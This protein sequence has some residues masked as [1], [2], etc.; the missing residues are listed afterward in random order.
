MPTGALGANVGGAYAAE[1]KTVFIDKGLPANVTRGRVYLEEIG[2]YLDT[3]VVSK[4]TAGDEGSLFSRLILG[5]KLTSKQLT[6]VRSAVDT[7]TFT[8][9]GK[10]L[11]VEHITWCVIPYVCNGS[12]GGGISAP[13]VRE[14]AKTLTYPNLA[15][16]GDVLDWAT[17]QSYLGRDLLLNWMGEDLR[18]VAERGYNFLT[19]GA[20]P[21]V[22]VQ[23]L[24]S[25]RAILSGIYNE[26]LDASEIFQRGVARITSGDF[27]NG[28]A[29]I[30]VSTAN[31]STFCVLN[32]NVLLTIAQETL[33][34]LQ[35]ELGLEEVGR[36]ANAEEIRVINRVFRGQVSTNP[37]VIKT[38]FAGL[39]S[40]K[41]NPM[42]LDNTIY[43]K[44]KPITHKLLIHETTHV[45]QFQKTGTKYKLDALLARAGDGYEWSKGFK[46][47]WSFAQLNPEQ[48]AKL[49]D[50]GYNDVL[51]QGRYLTDPEYGVGVDPETQATPYFLKAL[52]VVSGGAW[53]GTVYKRSDFNGVWKVNG[54]I[55]CWL[56]WDQ[57]VSLGQPAIFDMGVPVGEILAR[58]AAT[59][60]CTNA[61]AGTFGD[62]YYRSSADPT[63]FRLIGQTA[64]W[65]S[66]PQ[67]FALGQP[68]VTFLAPA[69]A[70]RLK[71]GFYKG[72]TCGNAELGLWGDGFYR[73]TSD[74]TVLRL[75]GQK[76]CWVSWP[77]FVAV[78]Q[79]TVGMMSDAEGARFRAGFYAGATCTNAELGTWTDGF[80]RIS[81]D[82]TI[83]RLRGAVA[84]WVTWDQFVA[85]RQPAQTLVSSAEGSRFKAAFVNNALC[86]NPELGL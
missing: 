62:G 36:A 25:Y 55:A 43:F 27:K 61:G 44:N 57:Y 8:W 67:F 42:T 38:G 79:P 20:N 10:K 70:T 39:L 51:G 82:P 46:A 32:P 54:D 65:V 71:A 86:T 3:V 37:I 7:G 76:A 11:A 85:L 41:P 77:Q 28:F 56:S 14:I 9:N 16:I 72:N 53:N 80:Y 52:S 63:V 22:Y 19:N 69:D 74:P 6:E 18:S 49:I 1:I 17:R 84:C 59:K 73:T 40:L 47:G 13:V 26:A 29:D 60:S 24:N 48:Q 12:G 81:N 5:E 15:T 64:C 68:A 50:G 45:W 2:H 78:G 58:G 33:T 21:L 75:V 30:L 35:V 4:D 83:Y 34:N 31:L 23:K 66:G